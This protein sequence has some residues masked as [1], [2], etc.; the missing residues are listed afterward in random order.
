MQ[1]DKVSLAETRAFSNFFLDYLH[2]KDTLK[3]FYNR[4]PQLDQFQAQI[5]EKKSSFPS[6]HREV[7]VNALRI[8][9]GKLAVSPEVDANIERLKNANTFSVT[10][11][12]QLNIFTGPLYFIFKIVTVI[13][14]CRQLKA[15]YPDYDFVPVYWMASEDHD[16]EEIKYFKLY[17]KKIVWETEQSGAVGRFNTKGLE[18]IAN[19]I[20]GETKVFREAYSKNKT[21]SAAVR[22]YVN[23][24]FANEGLVVIDGDDRSLKSL[25]KNVIRE[26]VLQHAPKKLVDVTNA[27]I[28]ALGYKTQIFCRD[29]NFFY[30]ADGIR[31]R[32][33]KQGDRFVVVDSTLSFSQT[34]IE[35]MIDEEPE[36]FSPNVILRPLY[37]EMI[38]PNV[39]YVGGPAEVIYWLQL[40]A[41]FDHFKTPFPMVMPRNFGMVMDH[42]TAR[43][44]SKTS[45]QLKDLFEE[46]NYIF[47]HWVLS[48]SE[49]NLTVGQERTAVNELF[50]ALK[51]RAESIDKTLEPFVAAEGKRALNSLEKIERKLLRAEKRQHS[52]K[53]RQI[54]AVKDALFPNGS[55]QERTDNFLNFHQRDPQFISHLLKT[56]DPLDYRFNILSYTD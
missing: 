8:Q 51:A 43:K 29:I 46:K 15:R 34:E 28:E 21:L 56:F 4:F 53:L 52:D 2:Q 20:S 13:N 39:S 27:A 40:K 12:H 31:S 24:L 25:F 49:R 45:L 33:E 23:A 48:N 14:T 5:E 16:Y 19:E 54:E 41:V 50:A 6:P 7:L 47:N 1:L 10:T 30:L 26:D 17:G 18:A 38:L 3:P 42:E 36:K 35:K 32:I 9:Y 55:L 44:F 11:G 22:H 37:Q